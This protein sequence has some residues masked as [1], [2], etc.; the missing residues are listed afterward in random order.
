MSVV[1]PVRDDR[2][3][4]RSRARVLARPGQ[5][6]ATSEAYH[7]SDPDF[8]AASPCRC[9]GTARRSGIVNSESGDVWGCSTERGRVGRRL[10]NLCPEDLRGGWL[11]TGDGAS[12]YAWPG[13]AD[14]STS[15]TSSAATTSRTTPSTRGGRLEGPRARPD[16]A[17]R[18]RLSAFGRGGAGPL[19]R[20]SRGGWRTSWA[21]SR[22]A[23]AAAFAV[24]ALSQAAGLVARPDRRRGGLRPDLAAA[25]TRAARPRGGGLAGSF[26]RG[27]LPRAS[28]GSMS[29]IAPISALGAASPGDLNLVRGS[30]ARSSWPRSGAHRR[31]RSS[32]A[33]RPSRGGSGAPRIA[34]LGFGG[35]FS[36]L[37][38]AADGEGAL[39]CFSRPAGRRSRVGGHRVGLSISDEP[40]AAAG[41][42]C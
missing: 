39:W 29:V 21:G 18:P 34:A 22:A 14:T 24:V 30:P 15:T 26:R 13:I 33:P 10:V 41:G 2:G 9:C 19:S 4:V 1:N 28:V 27:L 37:A 38:E 32:R 5:R 23:G 36:L 17:A 20:G 31:R 12:V 3:S 8:D 11:L 42:C 16:Q 7:A 6:V 25:R 40:R 35:F